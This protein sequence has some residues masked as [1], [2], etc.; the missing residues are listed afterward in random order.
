MKKGKRKRKRY[1]FIRQVHRALGI[2]KRIIRDG[3]IN[4]VEVKAFKQ[5]VPDDFFDMADDHAEEK[6]MDE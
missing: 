5:M 1:S 3:S 6:I 4:A 2:L